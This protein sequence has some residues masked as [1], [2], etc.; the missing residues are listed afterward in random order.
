MA[1][2]KA[3]TFF[4]SLRVK[5]RLAQHGVTADKISAI[6]AQLQTHGLTA[7]SETQDS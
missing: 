4:E 6:V 2:Q 1:I 5:T 7:L 3:R